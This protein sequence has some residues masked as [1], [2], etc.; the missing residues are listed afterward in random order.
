[1]K[2]P[3]EDILSFMEE[4]WKFS[5]TPI[6]VHDFTCEGSGDPSGFCPLK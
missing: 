5:T 4:K 6:T 2:S 3:N 1:M